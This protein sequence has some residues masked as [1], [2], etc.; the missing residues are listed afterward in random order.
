MKFPKQIM[1]L[2]KTLK[3]KFWFFKVFRQFL[4][5]DTWEMLL[6]D[7]YVNQYFFPE[8]VKKITILKQLVTITIYD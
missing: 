8:V 5:D 1:V 7:K 4:G 2:S 3:G 6:R